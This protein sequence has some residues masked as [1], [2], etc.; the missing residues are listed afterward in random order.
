ME[1]HALEHLIV[2]KIDE[3]FDDVELV[4]FELRGG[5]DPL[6]TVYI[7]SPGGVDLDLCV[8]VTHALDVLRDAYRLEVSS[9]GLDRPLRKAEQFV[10]VL[11]SEVTV[12]T[13]V[14]LEGRASY[15]GTL[16]VAG[17]TAITVRLDD[18]REV[19]IPLGEVARARLV[20]TF[21]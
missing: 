18:G 8:A 9:P 3:Q 1:R 13:T 10:R 6:L 7:D 21:D 12:K 15:R 5:R 11:G 16:T 14:P 19:T 17:E 2:E 20:P 4:D